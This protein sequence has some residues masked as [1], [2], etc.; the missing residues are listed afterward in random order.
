MAFTPEVAIR[1][2]QTPTSD[3]LDRALLDPSKV[4]FKAGKTSDQGREPQKT[5][6]ESA[7]V[8]LIQELQEPGKAQK[9]SVA[10]NVEGKTAAASEPGPSTETKDQLRLSGLGS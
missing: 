9:S 10:T 3:A 6:N 8:R 7:S 4:G 5:E 1:T 2:S